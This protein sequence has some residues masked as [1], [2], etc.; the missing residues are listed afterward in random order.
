MKNCLYVVCVNE[1]EDLWHLR[2]N[3]TQEVIAT[4]HGRENILN[5]VYDICVAYA[6]ARNFKK[7]VQ[8]MRKGN[9]GM[10]IETFRARQEEAKLV[11]EDD[12]IAVL[13]MAEQARKDVKPDIMKK[14]EEFARK[15]LT[16]TLH[17]EEKEE[18]AEEK[19]RKSLTDILKGIKTSG[20]KIK[21][22]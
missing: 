14:Q 5:L 6:P 9:P 1:E 22:C 8:E 17:T 12:T 16:L 11:P 13:K 20:L 19:P 15:K 10:S 18:I 4:A 2:E 3:E 21:M 7:K